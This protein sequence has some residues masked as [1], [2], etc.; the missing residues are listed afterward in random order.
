M[1]E[2]LTSVS[3]DQMDRKDIGAIRVLHGSWRAK[4]NRKQDF[5]HST[6]VGWIY[7]RIVS[8]G[9]DQMSKKD[10]EACIVEVRQNGRRD[11]EKCHILL[12]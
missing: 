4:S 3:G 2:S 1:A 7:K 12:Q 11:R 9:T 10:I 5:L 8:P 6:E